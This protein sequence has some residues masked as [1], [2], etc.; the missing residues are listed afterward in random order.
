M[1]ERVCPT[2]DQDLTSGRFGP[3]DLDLC[4]PC[5]GAW[6]D[7]GELSRIIAAGPAVV[8]RLGERI[9][10]GK[11]AGKS[12]G[13]P[14]CPACRAGLAPTQLASLPGVHLDT[15]HFCEGTW[16]TH[17]T[18]GRLAAALEGSSDWDEAVA[19]SP[20]S[21]AATG[22]KASVPAPG[23]AAEKCPHCGE[24]NARHAAV[25]WACGKA[26]RSAAVGTCPSCGGRM[27]QLTV[28]AVTF[29]ACEGCSGI[30]LSPNRMNMLL[31]MPAARHAGTL[32]QIDELAA[33]PA[34]APGLKVICPHC[35][36][37]MQPARLGALSPRPLPSCPRC[38]GLFVSR[39]LLGEILVGP[40]DAPKTADPLR[41]VP[42]DRRPL[43]QGWRGIFGFSQSTGRS[44]YALRIEESG[45]VVVLILPRKREPAFVADKLP[46]DVRWES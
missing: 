45:E 43:R 32:K 15:C 16:A 3:L 7:Q 9:T 37:P 2:C 35:R 31:V 4:L 34:R 29:D 46:A 6:F 20:A 41:N 5:G 44:Y 33:G 8:R 30:S 14:K 18:L 13:P 25:C 28:G 26:L 1:A 39:D 42:W 38:F 22:P 17:A 40:A 23:S 36:V 10:P 12:Q 11:P 21:R 19:A 27:R 24:S